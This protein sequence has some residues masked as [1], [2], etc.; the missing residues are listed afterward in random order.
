MHDY[1]FPSR[2]DEHGEKGG[3][4]IRRG[5][6]EFKGQGLEEILYRPTSDNAVVGKNQN[7]RD[8]RYKACPFPFGA[9]GQLFH[10]PI[11]IRSPAAPDYG[12]GKEDRQGKQEAA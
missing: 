10:G 7:R 2:R 12:L 6:V 3:N 8:Y 1:R 9:R 4:P 5:V 11:D